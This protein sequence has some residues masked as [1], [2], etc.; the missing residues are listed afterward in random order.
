M[1]DDQ[2]GIAC[3]VLGMSLFS[4]QDLLIRNLAEDGSLTQIM[5]ARGLVGGV[6]LLFFLRLTNRPIQFGS[7]FPLL[8]FVRVTLFFAGFLCFY[9]AL[10][11]MPLAEATSLFFISPALITLLSKLV[12]GNPIGIYRIGAILAG[13]GGV[14]LI[15]K[16]SPE[17]FDPIALLPLLSAFTYSISMMIARYTREKDSVWQQ[18]SH[19]YWGSV[20]LGLV[21]WAGLSMIDFDLT[22]SS[23]VAYLLRDWNVTELMILAPMAAIGLVGS[24]GMLLLTTAYRV[25]TPAVIAPFEYVLMP[26]AI[27]N[28]YFF[29]AE[30]PDI[31]SIAGIAL[32]A[33]SGLFIFF[34]EG[35]RKKPLAVKT[36]LRT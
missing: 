17:H 25:G 11:F 27:A 14:L 5:F 22:D 20:G 33:A 23:G 24:A 9:F 4:I 16:P 30:I 19:M 31:Y 10:S 29:F 6:L 1:N 26:L 35:V 3:I 12:F 18:M 15:V 28:G 13:F 21:A 32:I 8:A 34:R 7:A 36:S 2:R